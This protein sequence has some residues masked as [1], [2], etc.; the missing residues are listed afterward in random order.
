M[1]VPDLG[2]LGL[3]ALACYAI[4]AG[5]YASIHEWDGALWACHVSCVAIGAGC[6]L[7]S[8][9]LVAV[10]LSLL[11]VGVPLWMLDL[12][13]GGPLYPTSLLTHVGGVAIGAVALRALGGWPRG[14]WWKTA[15]LMMSLCVVSK[16]VTRP[17]RNINLVFRVQPGW[18][19]WFPSFF[20]YFILV[21]VVSMMTYWAAERAA[22]SLTRS[23]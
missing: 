8:A 1:R 22:R 16:H 9:D 11:A 15:L 19:K 6:L 2:L 3:L 5:Y 17:E 12:A 4:H 14:T 23:R 13:T 10:G 7:R 21:A 20:V 18:E